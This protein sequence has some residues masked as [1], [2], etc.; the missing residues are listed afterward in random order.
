MEHQR[1]R[2][3]R[4]AQSGA[5]IPG[6]APAGAQ[7]PADR[8]V[9]I[10]ELE[11]CGLKG[12]VAAEGAPQ[13]RR[14]IVFIVSTFVSHIY[15]TM[16]LA[17]RLQA[18]GF[19]VEYWGERGCRRIVQG[20]GF[21]HHELDSVW[22]CYERTALT[23]AGGL[24]RNPRSA[25][26]KVLSL[27]ARRRALGDALT[28]F[29]QSLE[30]QLARA[31]PALTIL[32]PMVIAYYP[33]LR[34]RGLRCVALQDKPLPAA[35][36]LVPPPT[37]ALVPRNTGP[38]RARIRARWLQ[39]R[40][41]ERVRRLGSRCLNRLGS[42]TTEQLV[43][44]A[45]RRSG[46][47]AE[48]LQ[49]RRRVAYE[50]HFPGLE[51]W[52]LGAPEADFPRLHPLSPNIRYIGPCVDLQRRQTIVPVARAPGTRYLI[53]ISMGTSVPHWSV[54]L[55]LLRRMVAAF[56]GVAGLQVMVALGNMRARAELS[57][58]FDNV[59]VFPFLPQL[60]VLGI[61]DLAITHAGAN[62]FRECIATNTPMLAFPRALDQ[63]GN[64]A[65]IVYHGL[66]LRGS[67]LLDSVASIRR[68]ALHILEDERFLMRVRRLNDSLD[69]SEQPLLDRALGADR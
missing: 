44:A 36:P 17:R 64:A 30:R 10:N 16:G 13:P 4:V 15:G 25:V 26:A 32:D 7:V 47:A 45:Q 51:E 35:D 29:E 8:H 52:V 19:R 12:Q 67:R 11:D 61:A 21:A 5:A 38:G 55:A 23:G 9:P 56:G 20:Q 22:Y 62:A 63:E 58:S 46:L 24:L 6:A 43:T 49:A 53:Y 39:E 3:R 34:A 50:L 37:S 59:H 54:D 42:Y 65:R 2:A 69:Q 27:R 66:G 68:K 41:T 57:S 33:L 28:S 18:R 48:H 40:L 60:N 14:L 1:P 31:A